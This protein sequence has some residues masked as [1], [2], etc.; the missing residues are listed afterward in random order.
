MLR[1]VNGDLLDIGLTALEVR[2][3]S[4][5]SD[6]IGFLCV[7]RRILREMLIYI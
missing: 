2:V 5:R 4:T 7:R 3:V 1:I 6:E